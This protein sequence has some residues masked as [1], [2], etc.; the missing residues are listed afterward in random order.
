M[1]AKKKKGRSLKCNLCGERDFI[2]LFRASGAKEGRASFFPTSQSV[3]GERIVKCSGCGLVFVASQSSSSQI[4][5]GYTRKKE[6]T[7]LKDTEARARSFRRSAKFLSKLIGKSKGR[8]LDVGCAAGLFLAAARDEGFEVSGVE[9]NRWLARWGRE[10]LKA[11]ITT[12]SFEEACLRQSYFEV[13]TF[14]DVLEHLTDPLGA[15]E[16]AHRLLQKEGLML[17]NYPD[18]KSFWA[19]LLGRNWWFVVSGHL[20]YFTPLTIKQMVEKAGFQVVKDYRHFQTLSLGYL[21]TRLGRYNEKLAGSFSWLVKNVGL[22]KV[23][24]PYFAGQRTVI[25][26]RR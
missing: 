15:L 23:N 16:K 21:L 7:Y 24:V 2:F 17:I 6:R 10:N 12:G 13:V 25:A 18:I 8:L 26:R 9:P 14:W 19:R 3:A 11:K 22:G 20:F 4:M 5:M 1:K